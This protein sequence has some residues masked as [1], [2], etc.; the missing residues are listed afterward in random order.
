MSGK[1]QQAAPTRQE[2]E[3]GS[4]VVHRW[5]DFEAF[6]AASDHGDGYHVIE[7]AYGAPLELLTIGQPFEQP[8]GAVMVVFSGAVGKRKERKPPFVSGRSLGPQL[9]VPL[10]AISDPSLAMRR[11]FNIAWY[12]GSVFQDVQRAVDELLRPLA[13]RLDGDLWLVGG[14]AGGFGALQAAHR[15]GRH[16]S[17]FVWNPQTDIANYSALYARRYAQIAFPQ[18]AGQLEGKNWKSLFRKEARAHNRC[19]DLIRETV[20]A[21]SPR[22]LLYLQGVEDWHLR[23]HCVPYLQKHG[24][25]RR[26]PGLWARG[27]NQVIWQAEAGIGHA[28]PRA[29]A[30]RGILTRLLAADDATVLERAHQLDEAPTFDERA[31]TKRP[32]PL[33]GQTQKL[34]E[35][36][37]WRVTGRRIVAESKRLPAGFGRMR[38]S[39][40]VLDAQG[41]E[42]SRSSST[43]IPG[44]WRIPSLE[45]ADHANIVLTDG[46]GKVVIRKELPL[47]R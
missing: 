33:E 17:A 44:D 24:Y 20:P 18:L 37:G 43:E 16:C 39:A 3:Y 14:S 27:E 47:A 26:S 42:L 35:L 25:R 36:V 45:G 31:V 28:P 30:I 2:S 41:Q 12:A 9:G 11:D 1:D 29:E 19:V 34:A 10:I 23:V 4:Q 32:E 5:A 6:H 21:Q 38:W 22:R 13:V 7:Q 46:F 15:L 40:V 8:A